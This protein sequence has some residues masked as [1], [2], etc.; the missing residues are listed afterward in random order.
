MIY[1]SIVLAFYFM[2]VHKAKWSLK[3][4]RDEIVSVLVCCGMGAVDWLLIKFQT[5][6]GIE[7]FVTNTGDVDYLS[8]IKPVLLS[9][10]YYVCNPWFATGIGVCGIPGSIEICY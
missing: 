6:F 3:A 1:A 9:I 10:I 7:E 8:R 2:Y 5:I 4:V